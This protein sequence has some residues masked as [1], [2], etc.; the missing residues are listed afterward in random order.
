M[1]FLNLRTSTALGAAALFQCAVLTACVTNQV[2]VAARVACGFADVLLTESD[3]LAVKNAFGEGKTGARTC[4]AVRAFFQEAS[5]G[6]QEP[7]EI[8]GPTTA[9]ITL[10]DG[11]PLSVQL[12]P[13]KP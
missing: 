2:G 3:L 6:A 7:I 11:T 5:G 4:D 9:K 12:E 13:P 1:R 10:P 8:V